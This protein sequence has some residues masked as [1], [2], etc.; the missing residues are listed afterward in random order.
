VASS[1]IYNT[2]GYLWV[3]E[4]EHGVG[5]VAAVAPIAPIDKEY[6]FRVP[7]ELADKVEPG[8]RVEVPL[9]RRGRI[10]PAFCVALDARPWDST[11]KAIHAVI[12]AES[13]LTPELLE[14]GR[15]MSRYYAC[16]LG[17]TLAALVPEA[18]RRQTGF[19]TVQRVSLVGQ[20]T[21]EDG[22]QSPPYDSVGQEEPLPY[23][24]GSGEEPLPHGRGSDKTPQTSARPSGRIGPKQR[25][26]IEYLERTSGLAA[27]KRLL[28]DTGASRATVRALESKGWLRFEATREPP[29]F[30]DFDQPRNEPDFQLNSDQAAAVTRLAEIVDAREFRVGLLFGVSGSGK[31]EVYIHAM[32]RVLAQGRQVVML[33]PEIALTTQPEGDFPCQPYQQDQPDECLI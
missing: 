2:S 7:P 30:P 26:V 20:H 27:M 10:T 22:G 13:F 19:R 21:P 33:V 1:E 11:L 17:R 18:V 31:T 28:A 9:G 6:S 3:E 4:G 29:P 8:R 25:A 32:R 23:G 15:W 5:P 14:L 16:P 12:D 24:R